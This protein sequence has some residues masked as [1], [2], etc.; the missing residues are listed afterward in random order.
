MDEWRATFG[1]GTRP[2]REALLVEHQRILDMRRRELH[3]YPKLNR[4][5]WDENYIPHGSSERGYWR[6]LQTPLRDRLEAMTQQ[7][8][9]AW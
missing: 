4:M 9:A 3:L 7:L 1:V 8:R 2:E 6:K 5:E